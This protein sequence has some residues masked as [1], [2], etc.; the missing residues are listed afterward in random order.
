[1]KLRTIAAAAL[2]A[3]SG[4]AVQSA[5]VDAERIGKSLTAAGSSVDADGP[6]PKYE[7]RDVLEAGW[8]FGKNRQASW[9]YHNEK[10]LYTI[11]G[12][13][14]TKYAEQLTPGQQ[15]VFKANPDYKMDVYPTHRSCAFPDFVVENTR[16]NVKEAKLG[17]DGN[18]LASGVLPGLPFPAT[19]NGLEAIWNHLLRYTGIGYDT[20]VVRTLVSP[21][22]GSDTWI[23][24]ITDTTM[25]FPLNKKGAHKPTDFGATFL[26]GYVKFITP[27]AMAGQAMVQ[28]SIFAEQQETYFYFPGQRRVR[29]MPTYAYDAPMLGFE[30]QMMVDAS[31]TF[32]GNPD[33]YDWKLVGAKN[34]LM[35]YN[36]FAMYD[37][38]LKVSEVAGPK[39]V[40]QKARRYELHKVYV[41]EATVKSGLRHSAP[42]RTFFLDADTY[43]ALVADDYD[44]QGKLWKH[45][46]SYA[47]PVHE[48]QGA[49]ALVPYAQY[50]L[51]S[52]RYFLDFVTAETPAVKGFRFYL[53][54]SEPRF[55]P[56][57]YTQ[58]NLRAMSE[59]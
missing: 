10:P 58:D 1:M 23:D 48:L 18:S 5:P 32:N 6:I 28:R 14:Y 27:A 2:L 51:Q 41:V 3:L 15:S 36:A 50:D 43:L 30:N 49:C 9:K 16:R 53:D 29:R 45:R 21:R 39:S 33:R 47:M 37:N 55:K 12:S 4:L 13:N 59:R 35:P 56:D 57:F 11:D 24:T 22:P 40:T 26:D 42:K 52:G 31:F 34:M 25:F 54:S 19:D 7:G 44:A 38:E 8:T 46:E 17:A 20:P